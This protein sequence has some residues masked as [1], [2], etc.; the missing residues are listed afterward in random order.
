MGLEGILSKRVR[1]RYRSGRTRD[2]LKVKCWAEG[3]F[4]VVG[5]ERGKDGLAVALLAREEGP[6]QV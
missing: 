2:W 6:A 5:V 1:S 4:L 3:E